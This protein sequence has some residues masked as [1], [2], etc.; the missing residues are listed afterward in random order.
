[1]D[2]LAETLNEKKQPDWSSVLARITPEAARGKRPKGTREER[3][4]LYK[5]GSQF[6]GRKLQVKYFEL[7]EAGIPR[8]PTTKSESYT[9]YIRDTIE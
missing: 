6:I 3:K 7:T 4:E 1:V 8:F 9:T 2:D 5:R